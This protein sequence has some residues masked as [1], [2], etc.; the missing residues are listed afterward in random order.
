MN[1]IK[2]MNYKNYNIYIIQNN[3]WYRKK[4]CKKLDLLN[5]CSRDIIEFLE[6]DLSNHRFNRVFH[7]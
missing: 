4:L 6:I 5:S 1:L 2:L 3:K 7:N